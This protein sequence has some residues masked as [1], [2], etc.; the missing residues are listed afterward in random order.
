MS[1]THARITANALKEN[2]KNFHLAYD[3]TSP[4]EN[5]IDQ[6]ENAVDFT[7]TGKSPYTPKHV[8]TAACN[9]IHESGAYGTYCKDWR[10]LQDVDQT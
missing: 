9:P 10:A 8:V 1:D 3:S 5:L 4:F 6:M 2:D 7:S